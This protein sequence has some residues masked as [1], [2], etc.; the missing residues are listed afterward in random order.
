MSSK[1][2]MEKNSNPYDSEILKKISGVFI[3]LNNMTEKINSKKPEIVIFILYTI[4]HFV[5][6]AFHEPWYDEAVAWMIAKYSSV[7]NIM[8][9][10][11][12]YEGHPQLWFFVL[13]P[14]ARL[15]IPYELSLNIVGY[16]FAGL[17]VYIILFKS[18]FPKLVRWLLPFTYFYLYQ[19]GVIVRPYCIMMLAFLLLGMTYKKRDD[20]PIWHTLSLALLALTSAYGVALAGCIALVWVIK[21]VWRR[22]LKDIIASIKSDKRVHCLFGLLVFA[23]CLMLTLLPKDDTYA[24]VVF[25]NFTDKN[26]VL[27]Q[28]VYM[29]FILPL[30]VTCTNVYSENEFLVL[31][32]IES[33][34]LITMCLIGILLWCVLIYFAKRTKTILELVLPY[35]G[36]SVFASLV[37]FTRH[38]MGIS[39]MFFVYWAY[40]SAEKSGE[41]DGKTSKEKTY[42]GLINSMTIIVGSLMIVMSLFWTVGACIIEV[43][44]TY[45]FGR[46]EAKFINDNNLT[47]YN[48]MAEWF[49]E[50]R[51][52]DYDK[53]IIDPETGEKRINYE[54]KRIL[55]NYCAYV[56]NI[57]PYF[58]HNIF[59]NYMDGKESDTFL[60]HKVYPDEY[61]NEILEKWKQYGYPDILVGTPAIDAL[62]GSEISI[63]DDYALVFLHPMSMVWKYERELYWSEIYIRRDLLDESGLKEIIHNGLFYKEE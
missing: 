32:K 56:D 58:D 8:F 29:I 61:N 44:K 1:K 62:F 12:H 59:Y 60:A 57:D 21:I 63:K 36:F 48:I 18:P 50:D 3:K 27:F 45:A 46:E 13:M 41:K 9:E 40:V 35:V 53:F 10:I 11:P 28:L 38:H 23:I 55:A 30:D 39:L 24:R 34:E 49:V 31:T 14:F 15:G 4:L 54:A 37:Y 7:M 33:Y 26:S 2:E 16:I 51:P 52:G 6:C 42:V 17:S 43:Q 5:I 22:S 47:K 25:K 19:Y 20:K